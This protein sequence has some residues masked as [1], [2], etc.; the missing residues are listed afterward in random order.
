M[1]SMEGFRRMPGVYED[2]AN[3]PEGDNY[4]LGCNWMGS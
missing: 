3:K 1:A 2:E 4:Y